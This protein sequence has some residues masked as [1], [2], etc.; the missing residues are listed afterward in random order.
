VAVLGDIKVLE[1][2]LQIK[3]LV[4]DS[5][6]V[7]C[8]DLLH[9]L[10]FFGH[11]FQI[12]PPC[13]QC[14]VAGDGFDGMS[15]VLVDAF[16]GECLIDAAAEGEVVEGAFGV[17]GSVPVSE[18]VELLFCEV[19]VEHGEDLFELGDGDLS[20]PELVEVSEELLHTHS[21]H[22]HHGLESL[23]HVGRVVGNVD[24]LLQEPV[25]NHV[26]SLGGASEELGLSQVLEGVV[27]WLDH[28]SSLALVEAWEHVLWSVHVLAEREVIHLLGVSLVEVLSGDELKD[29][30]GGRDDIEL[31]EHSS[32]L[33]SSHMATFGLVKV[34]E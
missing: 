23:L 30:V 34:L 6:S 2:R 17:L 21:L 19:E 16:L 27:Q 20:F 12:L 11:S 13:E 7:F 5:L 26:E 8:H 9:L 32:E 18:G 1:H 4:D 14:V 24:C 28:L 31:F 29:L 10:V 22:H 33:A 25:L 15:G 3:S